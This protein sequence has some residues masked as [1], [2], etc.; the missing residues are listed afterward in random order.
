MV[1]GLWRFGFYTDARDDFDTYQLDQSGADVSGHHCTT[2]HD[3]D[4][5]TC[6][7]T[8]ATCNGSPIAGTLAGSTLKLDWQ[9]DEDAGVQRVMA[10]LTISADGQKMAGTGNSTKCG[11]QFL[12]RAARVI[13]GQPIPVP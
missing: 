13:F 4:G 3:C 9:F 5:G 2:L 11:C 7:V 12:L 8:G 1:A 6:I 10:E